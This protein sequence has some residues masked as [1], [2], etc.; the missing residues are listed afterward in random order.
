MNY[1]ENPRAGICASC[2]K[3]IKSHEAFCSRCGNKVTSLQSEPEKAPEP[4]EDTTSEPP[5]D[6]QPETPTPM[7]DEPAPKCLRGK[8]NWVMAGGLIVFAA[9]IIT[10]LIPGWLRRDIAVIGPPST[11]AESANPGI[12]FEPEQN[13][14]DPSSQPAQTQDLTQRQQE[15]LDTL[16]QKFPEALPALAKEILD[17]KLFLSAAGKA[18]YANPVFEVYGL[19]VTLLLPDPRADSLSKLG[20]EPYAPH[21][22]ARAYISGN[23]TKLCG[24]DTPDRIEIPVTLYYQT[25]IGGE[26]TLDWTLPGVF[27]GLDEYLNVFTPHIEQYMADIGFYNAAAE[28]LMPDIGSWNSAGGNPVWLEEYFADLADALSFKGVNINGQLVID[29]GKIE[30][31]LKERLARV[32][33]CDSVS[34]VMHAN[35]RPYLPY[36]KV[37]SLAGVTFFSRVREGLDAQYQSGSLIK[38]SSL[39]ELESAFLSAS[40][41][42]AAGVLDSTAAKDQELVTE[43]EYPFDWETLGSDG[44]S[45]CPELVEEIRSFLWS[46]DFDLM[47]LK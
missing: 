35:S 3:T 22:G 38:P 27:W 41:E 12:T 7:T 33:V 43:R 11:A 36:I 46:Y 32:W 10:L 29:S 21:S 44:V 1:P 47:F 39:E 13:T 28:L 9:V 14:P 18:S 19:D 8:V 37:R 31:V 6:T 45:A 17:D 15:I 20:I 16:A 40:W 34:V 42:T 4:L 26:Q 30:S 24:M 23:Y 2:G 5:Q 25:G